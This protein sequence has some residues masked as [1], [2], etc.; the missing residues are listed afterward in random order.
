MRE[1]ILFWSVVGAIVILIWLYGPPVIIAAALF[2]AFL[3]VCAGYL[4]EWYK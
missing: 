4:T 2:I 3:F 1:Y